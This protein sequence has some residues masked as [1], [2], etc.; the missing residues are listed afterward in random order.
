MRFT[1]IVLLPL[2]VSAASLRLRQNPVEDNQND[3]NQSDPKPGPTAAEKDAVFNFVKNQLFAL[4]GEY[5]P[6]GF[7][8]QW[9]TPYCAVCGNGYI[10]IN[11]NAADSAGYCMSN[12]EFSEAIEG[13]PEGGQTCIKNIDDHMQI[14]LA[15]TDNV[16]EGADCPN[17]C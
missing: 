13:F 17:K 10:S 9:P 2:A 4:T 5:C 11:N 16:Y 8:V 1:S 7:D 12:E 6:E 14:M 15:S 3:C